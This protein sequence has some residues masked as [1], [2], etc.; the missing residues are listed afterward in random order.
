MTCVGVPLG[1]KSPCQAGKE[2]ETVGNP[3]SPAK[4]VNGSLA[5]DSCRAGQMRVTAEMGPGCAKTPMLFCKGQQ[6]TLRLLFGCTHR[7]YDGK[8]V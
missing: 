6:R 3:I 4:A 7:R 2:K 5:S 1:A 8:Q